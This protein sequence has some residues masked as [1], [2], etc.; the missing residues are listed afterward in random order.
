MLPPELTPQQI[1]LPQSDEHTIVIVTGKEL[2][3]RR[4]ALR[5][6]ETFGNDVVAWYELDAS[7]KARF[8]DKNQTRTAAQVQPGASKAQKI[9]AVLFEELPKRFRKYGAVYTLK[10]IASL[11]NDAW[12]RFGPLRQ[13]GK[14]MALA[15]ERLFAK[16][17]EALQKQTAM[18]ARKLHPDD[19]HSE[20]FREEVQKLDPYFFLTLS[21]PLY[22]QPLLESIR[23]A[24]INQHA[25]HSPLYK[26]SNTIHWALYHRRLDYVSSTVHIT[27]TGAD[28]GQILRRSNPC[29]FPE[30]DVETVFLRTVALGTELMIE[31]V[32]GIIADKHVTVFEQPKGEGLTY[33][34]KSYTFQVAKAIVRDFS[35]GWL[36]EELN[37][38]RSF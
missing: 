21:G 26:G 36:R 12:Y 19:V 5:I 28:A 23:G 1:T 16:E 8:V 27:N 32:Q 14:K 10:R 20:G 22:H 33:L 18:Q 25:G 38:E 6:I 7:V 2:R 3:H 24:A 9:K 13:V 34:N 11:A 30:D 15:E 31:S 17:V 29:M 37:R 35:A 4:F